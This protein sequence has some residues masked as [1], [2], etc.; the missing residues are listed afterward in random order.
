MYLAAQDNKSAG[1]KLNGMRTWDNCSG[2]GATSGGGNLILVADTASEKVQKAAEALDDALNA[3]ELSTIQTQADSSQKALL[4]F[5]ETF[6]PG[7]PSEL[8]A[9]DPTT[10]VLLIGENPLFD[11][12]GWKQRHAARQKSK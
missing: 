2:G 11:I 8:A 3:I 1:W 7:S 12:S 9:K 4:F 6:G 5:L 10:V